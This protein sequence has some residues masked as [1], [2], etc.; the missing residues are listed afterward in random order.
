[1]ALTRNKTN[2]GSSN[3]PD[4]TP[5][6]ANSAASNDT[7][8]PNTQSTID[9]AVQKSTEEQIKEAQLRMLLSQAREAEARARKAEHEELLARRAIQP[10]EVLEEE[11]GESIYSEASRSV[12]AT[13]PEVSIRDIHLIA[14]RKFNPED[15]HKLQQSRVARAA[16]ESNVMT[17]DPAT[18]VMTLKR[19]RSTIKNYGNDA[20]IWLNCFI[21]YSLI[22]TALFGK[23]Q[24]QIYQAMML[25]QQQIYKHAQVYQ[26]EAVYELAMAHHNQVAVDGLLDALKWFPIPPTLVSAFLTPQ[27]VLARDSSPAKRLQQN[28]PHHKKPFE[29]KDTNHSGYTCNGWNSGA[30]SFEG[31]QRLHGCSRCRSRDHKATA[32]RTK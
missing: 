31:C 13:F 14:T 8:V 6:T 18:N 2:P 21:T 17:I 28:L 19:G 5:S 11:L 9:A 22:S 1:M 29:K 3:T 15:L 23:D 26:W 32:C 7:V 20:S 27:N 25:F 4:P 30:C 16:E 24:P 12:H 10:T